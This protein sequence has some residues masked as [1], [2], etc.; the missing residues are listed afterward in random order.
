MKP[1]FTYDIGLPDGAED[2]QYLRMLMNALRKIFE[3][4]TPD[5]VF[6]L[7]RIDPLKTNHFGRIA[8][9]LKGLQQRE[10]VVIKTVSQKIPLW[11]CCYQGSMLK[12]LKQA[13][14]AH[15]IIYGE[16]K[17]ISRRYFH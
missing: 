12:T 11:F 14:E 4:F 5:F 8:L 2:H 9:I 6:Y 13:I 15:A 16:A 17:D 7:A 1:S 3:E 10:R